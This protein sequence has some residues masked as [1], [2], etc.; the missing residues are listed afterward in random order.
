MS[1]ADVVQTPLAA[2]APTRVTVVST[3]PA[4]RSGA[5]WFWWIAGLSLVNIVLA[6]SGSDTN[7]V[8][9]LGITAVSD[10]IFSSAKA[11][12][13]TIDAI[14]LGFFFLM[15]R[16]AQRGT[17]WPFFLGAA[18]YLLDA[19]IYVMVKEWMP[20]AFHALALFFILNGAMSL[21]AAL[22]SAG[23]R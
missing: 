4:A 3:T 10:A 15:G 18:V 16:L 1:D 23:V 21:R 22:R 8:I 19:L 13:F 20:V 5:R 11:V 12:G 14:A 7:F 9:G 6:Q 2:A 17:L